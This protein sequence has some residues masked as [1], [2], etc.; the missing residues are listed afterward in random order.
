MSHSDG[1]WFTPP[2]PA[3]EV[4]PVAPPGPS[5]SGVSPGA[6]AGPS[7]VRGRPP[8]SRMPPR[9]NTPPP[10]VDHEGVPQAP[11]PADRPE[12][13]LVPQRASYDEGALVPRYAQR[14]Q[15]PG[16]VGGVVGW[17]EV[18]EWIHRNRVVLAGL[19]MIAAQLVWKA[20]F[21]NHFFFW[22]DDYHD[23]DLALDHGFTWG[24]LV[25]MGSGHLIPGVYALS[26]VLA[27]AGLYD[28][29]LASGVTLV[30]LAAASVAA[31]RL[32]RTLFGDRPAILVPLAVYLLTPL[33]LP[34]LGWWS[35]A[36]E[37]LPLQL[38]TFMALDSH[39]WYVR[40]RRLRHAVATAIW[41]AVGMLFFEK[42]VV[43]PL[44]LFAVTSAFFVDGRWLTA[45]GRCLVTYWRA[46]LLYVAVLGGYVTLVAVQLRTS[47]AKPGVPGPYRDVLTFMSELVKNTFIPGALGGPWQ[48][49]PSGAIAYSAPPAGLQW[50]SWIVAAAV[51]VVSIWNRKY[52][53]RAWAI[54]AG[55]LLA[56]D[57]GPVAIGRIKAFSGAV[58]GLE[59][60]Y[61]ADAVPVLAIC[62]GLAFLPVA[63]RPDTRRTRREPAGNVQFVTAAAAAVLG[64][65]VLGS[66]WSAQAY[67]GATTATQARTYIT[68]A[69]AALKAAPHGT[70]VVDQRVPATLTFGTFGPYSYASKV[71][72][73]MA[74]GKPA[75]RLRWLRRPVGD[76]D[77]LMV[78][79]PDGRLRQAAPYGAVGRP[80]GTACWPQIGHKVT[81]LLHKQETV[82]GPLTLHIAYLA[83]A[84]GPATVSFGG[85]SQPLTVRRGLHNVY[86]TVRG[87][88]DNFVVRGLGNNRL[89]IGDASVGVLL[90]LSSGAAIPPVPAS[91]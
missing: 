72:G 70:V 65:F 34:G 85:Q 52:A 19:V 21:L 44:L 71:V 11:P 36:V 8:E 32:L 74:R 3:G 78:L 73:E 1:S 84:T 57:M 42:G 67:Q 29:A 77:H 60:R 45:A 31:L 79:G 48:W 89:C 47:S 14:G 9:A 46:W 63:G 2:R 81:V 15:Q 28:W 87:T 86:L 53:W 10:R 55:W 59:T 26:W 38:A 64:A 25:H 39:V 6:A 5:G 13:T 69:R 80:L 50:L 4:T 88:G 76:I 51:V 91:G 61:V 75:S 90:P 40:R 68:N 43:L 41:L 22:Q 66:L 16:D 20:F 82:S 17:P 18:A 58:L 23:L 56:A 27:R 49:L 35:S 24:Y 62:L 33:T 54:L 7:G 12:T 37:S 83:A 30:I